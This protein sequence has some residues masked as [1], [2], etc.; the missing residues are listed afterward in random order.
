MWPNAQFP[1]DLVTFTE[2]ILNGKLY[3]LCSVFLHGCHYVNKRKGNI[4]PF[5]P[6]VEFHIETNHLICTTSQILVRA[7]KN[8]KTIQYLKSFF[9]SANKIRWCFDRLFQNK[10]KKILDSTLF[11]TWEALV[12]RY[13]V[14][15][16][17]LKFQKTSSMGNN[18]NGVLVWVT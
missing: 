9:T 16:C 10:M 18:F 14:V 3:F 8:K 17:P 15:S 11:H 6:S 5:S 12:Q 13:S 7:L 2:E 1:T 4:N